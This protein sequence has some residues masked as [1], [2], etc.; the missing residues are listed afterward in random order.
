[1]ANIIDVN[2]WTLL[3][4][5]NSALEDR[6]VELCLNLLQM[7]TYVDDAEPLDKM[8]LIEAFQ[9]VLV[10]KGAGE[11][12]FDIWK[13]VVTENCWKRQYDKF[14]QEEIN[15]NLARSILVTDNSIKVGERKWIKWK[16]S[17]SIQNDLKRIQLMCG[18]HFDS[19]SRLEEKDVEALLKEISVEAEG[20]IVKRAIRDESDRI[21]DSLE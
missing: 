6:D 13:K 17:Y 1:M 3:R 5:L 11:P 21:F 19:K 7:M 2:F 8:P 16:S 18:I 4:A 20:S 10:I 12:A 9:I 15:D 14:L